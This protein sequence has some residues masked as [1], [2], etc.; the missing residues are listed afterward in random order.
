MFFEGYRIVYNENKRRTKFTGMEREKN[1]LIKNT[2]HR[3]HRMDDLKNVVYFNYLD[4]EDW[5]KRIL[6]KLTHDLEVENS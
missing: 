5:G 1:E 2:P 4:E 6:A 3:N